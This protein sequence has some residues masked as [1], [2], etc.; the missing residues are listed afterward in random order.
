MLI[1]FYL[2]PEQILTH[3]Y[4]KTNKKNF[5]SSL[6]L[7]LT[8]FPSSRKIA[9]AAT[10]LIVLRHVPFT[11]EIDFTAIAYD[12]PALNSLDLTSDEY[13][14][15]KFSQLPL[16]VLEGTIL[17]DI[18]TGIPRPLYPNNINVLHLTFCTHYHIQVSL[19]QK[20]LLPARF[21]WPNM[22]RVITDWARACL[23]CQR[24]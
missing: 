9:R 20:Y 3:T 18:A 7:R 24:S 13:S 4:Q 6:L 2:L 1:L 15:C 10:T 11:C 19:F 17:C 16:S 23:K 12:Q 22:R 14:C 21:F 8:L 5:S